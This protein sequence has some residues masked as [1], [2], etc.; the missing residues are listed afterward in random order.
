[1]TFDR[2]NASDG[3]SDIWLYD[4]DRSEF[5]SWL[6]TGFAEGHARISPDGQWIAYS[7]DS[8]GRHEVYLRRFDGTGNLL[9]VSTAGGMHPQFRRDGR[10]L[11]FLGPG[12]ELMA[13]ALT[14]GATAIVAGAPQKL[15]TVPL[16]DI[17]RAVSAPY[18][19]SA[20]GRRFLLQVPDR[21]EPLFFLQGL[22]ELVRQ[23]GG[24]KAR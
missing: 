14:P 2:Q 11:F 1:V 12:D 19:V 13:V 8:S 9:P 16:N 15:F 18:A 23:A 4:L 10:E 3:Q 24:L 20:D 21:P 17:T 22:G 6:S 5:K 7:S